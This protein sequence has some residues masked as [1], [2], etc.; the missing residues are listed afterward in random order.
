[1]KRF[2]AH[3]LWPSS[4]PFCGALGEAACVKCLLPLLKP[5]LP[6]D[7]GGAPHEAGGLHEGLLRELVLELKYS[8]NRPLGIAMG[9][10]LGRIFPAPECDIIIPVP[11]HRESDRGYN[12]SMAL[13][14]GISMEWKIPAAEGLRWSRARAAQT[15]LHEKERKEMPAD[16]IEGRGNLAEGRRVVLMDDV[17]T[18]GATLAAA[19]RGIKRAGGR[20]VLS[21]TWTIVPRT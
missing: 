21:V 16:A 5:P 18:T 15:S 12:Q 7:L 11:L 1:M 6:A 4:C 10:A 3:L 9:R 13:A 14:K 20:T 8:R 2:A 17:S 19:I